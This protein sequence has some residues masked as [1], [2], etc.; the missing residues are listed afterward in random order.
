MS[1]MTYAALAVL[2]L[3]FAMSGP[4]AAATII[5]ESFPMDGLILPHPCTLEPLKFE[6]PLHVQGR[7]NLD[8][9]G[10]AKVGLHVNTQ[11]VTATGQLSGDVY[12]SPDV[13]NLNLHLGPLPATGTAVAQVHFA[14][15][16]DDKFR[17][18]IVLHVT[19][20][21]SGNAIV[22]LGDIRAECR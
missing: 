10:G 19:V 17:L 16:G 12:H 8:G 20:S 22:K 9:S 13:V 15:P 4:A 21:E 14:G 5:N 11:G 7:V 2:C 6:G 3:F 18:H 1:R